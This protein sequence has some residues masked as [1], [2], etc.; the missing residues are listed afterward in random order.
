MSQ[1]P[2]VTLRYLPHFGPSRALS[3]FSVSG[4]DAGSYQSHRHCLPK[5]GK[6]KSP[7]GGVLLRCI[8]V[9]EVFELNINYRGPLEMCIN[10]N[11]GQS[12][13]LLFPFVL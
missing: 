13:H 4:M 3:C 11:E 10:T 9:S 6:E 1:S 12:W 7:G 2:G 5:Q 8:S